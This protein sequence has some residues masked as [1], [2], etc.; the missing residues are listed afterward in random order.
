MAPPAG[1]LIDDAEL[2]NMVEASLDGWL[3]TGRLNFQFEKKLVTF[4]SVDF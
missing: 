2:K 1:K 4:L 3:N